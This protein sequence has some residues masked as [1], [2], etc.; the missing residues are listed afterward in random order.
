[1]AKLAMLFQA[2]QG[3]RGWA[4]LVRPAKLHKP[5]RKRPEQAGVSTPEYAYQPE[6]LLHTAVLTAVENPGNLPAVSSWGTHTTEESC[7]RD[8]TPPLPNLSL[9]RLAT[10]SAAH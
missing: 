3:V 5:T 1:M 9:R 7:L 8:V 6:M 2:V 4:I 10:S